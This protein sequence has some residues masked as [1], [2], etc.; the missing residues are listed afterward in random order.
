MAQQATPA[1]VAEALKRAFCHGK[2]VLVCRIDGEWQ[3]R[4]Q[5]QKFAPLY[6]PFF[7]LI[8]ARFDML[9]ANDDADFAYTQGTAV[10]GNKHVSRSTII[11]A[12]DILYPN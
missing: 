4:V 11:D 1:E 12:L 7:N 9:F 8:T 3:W 5:G 6:D 2:Q 10:I